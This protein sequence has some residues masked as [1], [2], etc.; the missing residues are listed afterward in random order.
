MNKKLKN[1]IN[2]IMVV[3]LTVMLVVW[4]ARIVESKE[5]NYKNSDF[6]EQKEDF[7]VLFLGTSHVLNGVFPMEL[8]DDYGIVSYNF[9]GHGNEIPTTYWVME[10]ALDYTNPKLVVVDGY[11]IASSVKTA[12]NFSYL[13]LSFDRFPLSVNKVKAVNDLLD[14]EEWNAFCEANATPGSEPR[15]KIGLIWDYSLYHSRWTELSGEDFDLPTNPEKGAESRINVMEAEFNRLS[16]TPTIEEGRLGEMYLR[17]LIEECNSKGIDVLITYLPFPALGYEQGEANYLYDLSEEYGI[18]YINF[19]D[20]DIVDYKTDFYDDFAHLN[21]SGAR[22]ITSYLGQYISENYGITD[23]GSNSSYDY[24]NEDYE[25]YVEFKNENL[26]KE[27]DIYNYLMLLSNEKAYIKIDVYS[28]EL[29]K[30]SKVK[31]LLENTGVRWNEFSN[32]EST[33]ATKIHVEVMRDDI[34]IDSVTFNLT[35]DPETYE[36]VSQEAIRAED[37]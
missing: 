1:I 6:F 8:W 23:Q 17:R 2:C 35:L 11:Q 10:N 16:P 21:P 34:V 9:A 15:T 13:H 12:M 33:E 36:I 19:L 29:F 18:N 22:K 7:D 26:L 28:E 25:E 3:L 30:N 27:D 14:N 32:N 5:S 37:E 31:A 20:M 24:W 4:V